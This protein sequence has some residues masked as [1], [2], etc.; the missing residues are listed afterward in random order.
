[1]KICTDGCSGHGYLQLLRYIAAHLN[2][3]LSGFL[4]PDS[5]SATLVVLGIAP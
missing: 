3:E 4:V 1:M 2:L 5:R